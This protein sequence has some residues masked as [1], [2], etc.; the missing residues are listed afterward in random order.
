MNRKEVSHIADSI[1]KL[2]VFFAKDSLLTNFLRQKQ[3]NA[4]GTSKVELPQAA[5]SIVPP[6][7]S[8]LYVL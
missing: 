3:I 7:T 5:S 6:P 2:Y 4:Q 1:V 8:Y